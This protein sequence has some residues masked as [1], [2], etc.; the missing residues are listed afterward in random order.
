M[1]AGTW[2]H[3]PVT[4]NLCSPCG[5]PAWVAQTIRQNYVPQFPAFIWDPDDVVWGFHLL[6][7]AL[8]LW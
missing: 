5:A 3:L 6:C 1:S 4:L 2:G 8:F 7:A